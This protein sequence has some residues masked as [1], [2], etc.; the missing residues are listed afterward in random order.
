MNTQAKMAQ[1]IFHTPQFTFQ[2][3][4]EIRDF[5]PFYF[6]N[7]PSASSHLF[8]FPSQAVTPSPRSILTWLPSPPMGDAPDLSTSP[9]QVE[10]AQGQDVAWFLEQYF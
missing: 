4:W 2:E 10:M 1:L 6:F 3:V 7:C 5:E 8:S 9:N